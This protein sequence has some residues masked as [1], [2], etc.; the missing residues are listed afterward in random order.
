MMNTPLMAIA[1]TCASHCPSPRIRFKPGQYL[2]LEVVNSTSK[3]V[4]LERLPEMQR[5]VLKPGQKFG[6]PS[7]GTEPNLSILFWNQQGMYLQAIASK[8]NLG[9]L[10]L[11]LRPSRDFPGY[12]SLYLL[13]DGSV[14]LF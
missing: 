1:E 14:N 6:F 5:F 2:R 7:D 13:N 11:E 3:I 4:T 8:P 10:R 12:R 9:T